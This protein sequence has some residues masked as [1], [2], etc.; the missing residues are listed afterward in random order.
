MNDK[1]FE[2]PRSTTDVIC[3]R[4]RDEALEVLLV[5]RKYDPF[6]HQWA[7]PGGF[8][9]PDE[10]IRESAERELK[11][12]TGISVDHLR[13]FQ[14]YGGPD[15]DPRGPVLT[16]CYQGFLRPH[17]ASA[18]AASDAEDTK[19]HEAHNPPELA[20]DHE[21]ILTEANRHLASRLTFAKDAFFLLPEPFS[22]DQLRRVYQGVLR[23][24]IDRT[25]LSERFVD[26][27][28]IVPVSENGDQ[29]ERDTTFELHEQRFREYRSTHMP[30]SF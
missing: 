17:H 5:Q 10:T 28:L 9:E 24:T 20:F 22:L 21:R 12:E 15:R 26:N 18:E 1:T 2:G 14:S 11:E 7:I 8:V 30:F 27:G 25:T 16:V 13:Q 3:Y 23:S 4:F 6:Q 29:S 19:W